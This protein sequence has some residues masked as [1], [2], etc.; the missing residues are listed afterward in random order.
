[1]VGLKY[2]KEEEAYSRSMAYLKSQKEGDK[3]IEKWVSKVV[4]GG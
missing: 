4:S 1:L 2:L 3:A